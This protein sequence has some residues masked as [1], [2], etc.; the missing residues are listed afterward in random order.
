MQIKAL[1]LFSAFIFGFA[2]NSMAQ[3]S[4]Y[5]PP[6]LFDDQI[7]PHSDTGNIVEPRVST[8]DEVVSSTPV[9]A[10]TAPSIPEVPED[11][12]A[13]AEQLPQILKPI[14]EERKSPRQP[15][16]KKAVQDSPAIK[17]A[18]E[19][20]KALPPAP[21]KKPSVPEPSVAKIESQPKPEPLPEKAAE[22]KPP[23]QPRPASKVTSAGVV[24]GPVSMPSVPAQAVEVLETA[25]NIAPSTDDDGLTIMERHQRQIRSEKND[26]AP[27]KKADLKKVTIEAAKADPETSVAPAGFEVGEAQDVMKKMLPFQPG[28]IDLAENDAAAIGAGI[29][30]ELQKRDHWRIQ[31][32][33]YATPFGDGVSSDKRISLSRAIALRKALVDQGVRP[34]RIDVRA[35]GS[36]SMPEGKSGDRIDV[37]LYKPS[38]KTIVF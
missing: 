7:R 8:R 4:G 35:E 17:P 14:I 30:Q 16:I 13:P 12:A 3:D 18:K 36:A 10:P 2:H 15:E 1:L 32:R 34:S 26:S 23:S 20:V 25:T 11:V 37:Y 27:A 19:I 6:P 28:E 38:D 33:S 22:T 29:K 31:I 5:V 9:I 24:T 21:P